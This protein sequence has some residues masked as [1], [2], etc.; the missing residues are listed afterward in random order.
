[1]EVERFPCLP[2]EHRPLPNARS[3]VRGG[4]VTVIPLDA[5]TAAKA[6]LHGEKMQTPGYLYAPGLPG[7]QLDRWPHVWRA[8]ARQ[9]CAHSERKYFFAAEV[10]S[11]F[12]PSEFTN[13]VVQ[14][15]DPA[16]ITKHE[17]K[18]HLKRVRGACSMLT[19]VVTRA[20]PQ[21]PA[22]RPRIR[23]HVVR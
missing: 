11:S 7:C 17:K 19:Q 5:A 8:P 2:A 18:K 14:H 12:Q 6:Q 23:T 20:A 9:T 21:R 22:P 3:R 4:H 1:M 10:E 15:L 13:V 16:R